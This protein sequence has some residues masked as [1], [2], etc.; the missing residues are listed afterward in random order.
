MR[1][2]VLRALQVVTG[3]FPV[4]LQDLTNY[5][6]LQILLLTQDAHPS[7]GKN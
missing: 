7:N 2:L 3:V 5:L 4:F 1:F 6:V